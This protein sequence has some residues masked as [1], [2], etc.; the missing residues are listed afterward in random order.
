MTACAGRGQP[1]LFAVERS[2]RL[3]AVVCRQLRGGWSPAS[4]AGRLLIDHP[5]DQAC[6][7]SHEAIHQWVHAQPVST[8]ARE[9][10]ASLAAW[11]APRGLVFNED[12]TR[13][14]HLSEGFDFLGFSVRRYGATLLIKP[15]TKA[16]QRIRE[17]LRTEMRLVRGSNAA[18][19]L[20]NAASFELHGCS[21]TSWLV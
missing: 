13:I 7:V 4:V 1:T 8:L 2:P 17:R 5:G 6:R 12:K 20:T 10:K 18:A 16:I 11:L 3:R 9:I 14:A 15:S 21:L 19:V